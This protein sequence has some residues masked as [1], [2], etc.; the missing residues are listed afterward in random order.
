MA[1]PKK[2]QNAIRR[3]RN[4]KSFIRELLIDALGGGSRVGGQQAQT[5]T[6]N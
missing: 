4:Q 2:I 1:D 3:V 5:L 6:A